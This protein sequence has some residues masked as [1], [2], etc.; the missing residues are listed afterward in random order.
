MNACVPGTLISKDFSKAGFD[1]L[2]AHIEAVFSI[3]GKEIGRVG[4][5][6]IAEMMVQSVGGC[7]IEAESLQ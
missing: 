1:L 5:R 7:P 2:N 3:L 4:I 6:G